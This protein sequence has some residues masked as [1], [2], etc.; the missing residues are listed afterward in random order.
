LQLELGDTYT[1]RYVLK[2]TVHSTSLYR[3]HYKCVLYINP[4]IS[5]YTELWSGKF[6][7]LLPKELLNLLLILERSTYRFHNIDWVWYNIQVPV[8]IALQ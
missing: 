1:A 7:L 8:C 2:Y 6:L 4:H 3:L 5:C